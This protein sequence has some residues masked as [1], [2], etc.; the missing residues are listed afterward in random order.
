MAHV[1]FTNSDQWAYSQPRGC[2][3]SDGFRNPTGR[4]HFNED[5][6]GNSNENDN[7]LCIRKDLG[8]SMR[9][10]FLVSDQIYL[11]L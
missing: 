4:F 9:T 11:T 10:K 1:N 5:A 7:I 6:G 3:Q 2:F 8:N